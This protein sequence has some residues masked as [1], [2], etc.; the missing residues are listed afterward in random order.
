MTDP[1]EKMAAVHNDILWRNSG[2]R[3]LWKSQRMSEESRKVKMA[4]MRAAVIALAEALPTDAMTAAALREWAA[5]RETAYLIDGAK[6]YIRAAA[7]E[8]EAEGKD[9]RG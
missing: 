9:E 7:D 1:I 2:A 6:A 3:H 5:G 8:S 4:A